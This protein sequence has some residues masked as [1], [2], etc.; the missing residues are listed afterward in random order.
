M[1][2]EQEA[3]ATA[4]AGK[5]VRAAPESPAAPVAAAAAATQGMPVE[6]TG[7]GGAQPLSSHVDGTAV[8][9]VG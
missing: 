9:P 8:G 7:G 4:S 1:S 3:L 6:P 5:D 2:H